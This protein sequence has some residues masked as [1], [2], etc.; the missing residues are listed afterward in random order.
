M[1]TFKRNV[2]FILFLFLTGI[3]LYARMAETSN[4][5]NNISKQNGSGL[6]AGC[7]SPSAY[8]DI[9]FNN[10]KARINTGGDMW[11][12]LALRTPAYEIPKGSGKFS[13]FSGALWMGGQ[14]VN[15][16]LKIAAQRFREKGNDY[17]PGPLSKNIAE[18]DPATCQKYDKHYVINRS[19]VMRFSAWYDLNKSNPIQAAI[20]Y[21]G[22][23]IP[24]A[25]ENWPA[26]G[27]PSLGQDYY[28]APFYDND[29][30]GTY[31]PTQGDYP[32]YELKKEIYDCK[33]QRVEKLYGDQTIWWV[34]ND[35]GNIHSESGGASIGM[36]IHAQAF[37]FA[38]NDEINNMTFYN[39]A[40]IN[41]S[42]YTLTNT[43]FGV[44]VDSDLGYPTDDYVGCDVQRGLGYCYNGKA[45]D[46]QSNSPGPKEYGIQPP[47]VGVDFFEGPYQDNDGADNPLAATYQEAKQFNGIP[48]KG[49]G[50]GYGDGIVDNER[51]GMRRFLYHNIGSSP[52]ATGD[53]TSGTDYYNYLRGIWRDNEK[54]SYGGNGHTGSSGNESSTLADYMFPGDT[55]PKGWGTNGI[56]QRKWTEETEGNLPNDR[57]FAQSAGPFTLLPGAVNDIT[58]GV[59]WAR[60]LS[61][62]PFGSV[63]KLRAVDDKAQA[64]FDNCFRILEGPSAPDLT[65]KELDK[66]IILSL[67]NSSPVSNNKNESY[68]NVDFRIPEFF[69]VV[70]SDGSIK[71]S[72]YDRNYR[73]EGYL[74]F[75]VLDQ[76]ISAS[77]LLDY[78]ESKV[79]LIAKCDLKNGIGLNKKLINFVFDDETNSSKAQG[80]KIP[81]DE[82]GVVHSFRVTEDAF[83]Q[84]GDKRLVNYKQ[85][86]FIAVAYAYNNFKTYNPNL[87]DYLDGQKMPYLLSRTN[88]T[89]GAIT[90]SKAIPH[91]PKPSGFATKSIYGDQ[92][93]IKRLE[94]QGNGGMIL[95]FS[96]ETENLLASGSTNKVDFPKYKSGKGPINIKIVDPLAV[97]GEEFEVKF[98]PNNSTMDKAKWRLSNT[99]E[100]TIPND[101]TYLPGEFIVDS[102]TTI[103][104]GNEQLIPKLG[105][106][107]HIQQVPEPG[108]INANNGFAEASIAYADDSKAWLKGVSDQDGNSFFNWIRSGSAKAPADSPEQV[109]DDYSGIDPDEVYEKILSGT[110]AP[111]GLSSYNNHGPAFDKLSTTLAKL[112]QLKS[113]DIVLT[114][115][116]SK[117]TRCA[118][119]E[120]QNNPVF[121]QGGAKKNYLRNSPS[122]NKQGN[123]DGSGTIGMGWFPGYAISL[124][125]G[126]RLNMAFSEDSW[127]VGDNGRDMIWNPTSTIIPQGPAGDDDIRFGGKHFIYVFNN[128]VVDPSD[129]KMPAY[130]QGEFIRNSL[131][132]SNIAS[133]LR[134]VWGSCMWVCFPLLNDG[135]K[136]LSTDVRIRLRVNKA[137]KKYA[138]ASKVNDSNPL[139]SF[140]L[141]ELRTIADDKSTKEEALENINVVPNPYYAF[142]EYEVNQLDNKV[143]IINLPPN[144]QVSIYNVSGSLIRKYNKSDPSN[145]IDWDMK[146]HAGITIAGGV[147]LIHINVDGVGE[148]VVKWFGVLRPVDLSTF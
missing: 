7:A 113:V 124:E 27:D 32:K 18:I 115:D 118:V 144:C 130:D 52:F 93:I 123:D 53:P 1:N 120:N 73:F 49:I 14:D 19:D 133:G 110:V 142:S 114:A 119:F 34:F 59:V 97:N 44:W 29:L 35:K 77:D 90:V 89:G 135:Q 95:D 136:L 83:A 74:I 26:H 143:K 61:G 3:D 99:M 116:Q 31:D 84:G 146:N 128:E 96:S 101:K 54:M 30:D 68:N 13:I 129:S 109:Y 87:E 80:L 24:E 127:L 78:D 105:I 50:I 81:S 125:T 20:D 91:S 23:S 4:P 107:I 25:I 148:K 64:L 16:Q 79:K 126:E 65:V 2:L 67:S 88:G 15:G 56:P 62:G 94:G 6:R 103:S 85:Y 138:T 39:Y 122:V 141:K 5:G 72:A 104:I 40:L 66:E 98:L 43:Y 92:P 131:S 108:N 9:T 102:D 36:E 21:P 112:E 121:S 111:Y 100:F 63:E 22:Y 117:W 38:S 12:D 55:D 51:F 86:Y 58:V 33:S 10:V 48:Y 134:K 37:A 11:M 8:I 45:I 69:S 139:Y 106:S 140:N 70:Q 132:G 76:T 147:Y 75:Q 137:Y 145:Y 17:W 71:D 57:R 42:T 46:A 60:A 41:R 47:A 28:L 82:K